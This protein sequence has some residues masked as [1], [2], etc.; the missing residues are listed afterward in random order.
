MKD[1]IKLLPDLKG[2]TLSSAEAELM[3]DSEAIFKRFYLLARMRKISY[4]AH[5]KAGFSEAQAIELSK[6]L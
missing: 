6:N 2:D 4:K 3:R 1:N 5:I